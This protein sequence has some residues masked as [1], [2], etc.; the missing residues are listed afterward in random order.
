MIV[1]LL[2]SL[3]IFVLLFLLVLWETNPQ[4]VVLVCNAIL[5]VYSV[6]ATVFT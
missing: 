5:K 1:L 2:Y 3:Y 4:F 6:T